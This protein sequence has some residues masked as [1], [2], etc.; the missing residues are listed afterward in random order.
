[1]LKRVIS[2]IHLLRIRAN[3]QI[4]N[5]TGVRGR[6]LVNM[7]RIAA[8]IVR[9]DAVAILVHDQLRNLDRVD[10]GLGFRAAAQLEVH[11][12]HV[13]RRDI[14]L[15]PLDPVVILAL[16][17]RRAF[18]ACVV[19]RLTV[20]RI[21]GV[22]L[23]MVRVIPVIGI[24]AV[25]VGEARGESHI[26]RDFQGI[27]V[28]VVQ[29]CIGD[30]IA[31]IVLDRKLHPEFHRLCDR[32]VVVHLVVQASLMDG[33]PVPPPIVV[34]R[35]HIDRIQRPGTT[36]RFL[37]SHTVQLGNLKRTLNAHLCRFAQIG[38]IGRI[39]CDIEGIIQGGAVI[40][41]STDRGVLHILGLDD[42]IIGINDESLIKV[43]L[44]ERS[45]V[46]H[47]FAVFVEI[48]AVRQWNIHG[49][50]AV[51]RNVNVIDNMAGPVRRRDVHCISEEDLNG[52]AGIRL[53]LQHEFAVL[54]GYADVIAVI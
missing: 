34:V 1:M 36:V 18:I 8:S 43:Q 13:V 21:G 26:G 30:D 50:C 5:K 54:F 40:Q 41:V 45:H 27:P 25:P 52:F 24:N 35:V 7:E 46:H 16:E 51:N 33:F 19:V 39:A 9:F 11:A 32:E 4:L 48:L 44:L 28:G 14:P 22:F 23:V 2:Q 37:K 38:R 15:P 42:Q 29:L 6:I 12:G 49:S 3:I 47:D 10:L 31:L 17:D 20:L 53:S